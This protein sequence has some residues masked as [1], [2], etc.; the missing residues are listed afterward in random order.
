ME[1]RDQIDLTN[2]CLETISGISDGY[3]AKVLSLTPMKRLG[4]MAFE[5]ILT[6]LGM[7]IC[8]IAI[9]EDPE[10]LAQVAKRWERRRGRPRRQRPRRRKNAPSEPEPQA[11]EARSVVAATQT[12][13]DFVNTEDTEMAKDVVIGVRVDADLATRLKEAAD[14]DRRKVGDYARLALSD[15]LDKTDKTEQTTSTAT[16]TKSGVAA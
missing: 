4:P 16:T 14:K 11:V 2:E 6:A 10:A 15:A 8:A 1:R 13:F 5:M 7:G 3:A 9:S 12:V